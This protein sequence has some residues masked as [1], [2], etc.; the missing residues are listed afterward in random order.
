MKTIRS[1]IT[2][3][4]LCVVTF[5]RPESTA[6]V[7][8]R[9]T[10]EELH[11][12][13]DRISEQ[14]EL[15]GVVFT[16]AKPKIFIAGADLRGFATITP[17]E[18]A[19][20][21]RLGQ[22]AFSRIAGLPIPTVAAIHGACV[23]GGYELTLACDWRVATDHRATKIGLPETKLGILPAWGG[24]TRLPRLIGVTKALDIILNGK[25]V[26]AVVARK[27]GMIDEVAPHEYLMKA[28]NRFIARGKRP[29]SRYY[30]VTGRLI[31]PFVRAKVPEKNTRPLPRH[32]GG[33]RS[34]RG[35]WWIG[36]R[37]RSDP[38]ACKN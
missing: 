11:E 17:P 22:T 18:L 7:F 38:E 34:R 12:L 15:R 21:I 33:A 28:A 9:A 6:N 27:R 24:P 37:I 19:E 25:T 26:P 31:A 13:L 30:G 8:D 1:E 20:I 5:D 23:G 32:L 10:L 36:T 29:S 4:R 16:S 35:R 2:V 3:E 14:S